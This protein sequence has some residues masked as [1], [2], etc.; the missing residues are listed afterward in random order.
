LF[1]AGINCILGKLVSLVQQCLAQASR[2]LREIQRHPPA[3]EDGLTVS[4]W[5]PF[6]WALDE[7]EIGFYMED[8]NHFGREPKGLPKKGGLFWMLRR[9]ARRRDL[10]IRESL[11]PMTRSDMVA[12]E[13]IQQR[14]KLKRLE[15]SRQARPGERRD[16]E[17]LMRESGTENSAVWV[18]GAV[19]VLVKQLLEHANRCVGYQDAILAEAGEDVAER[20]RKPT[21]GLTLELFSVVIRLALA[22]HEGTEIDFVKIAHN[23]ELFT[24][25]RLQRIKELDVV[26]KARMV[27][28]PPVSIG[29][30]NSEQ[31][32]CEAIAT[33]VARRVEGITKDQVTVIQTGVTQEIM[34]QVSSVIKEEMSRV[35]KRVE[36]GLE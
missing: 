1:W 32:E 36:K 12:M 2:R 9:R 14:E 26:C 5:Y 8:Y 3:P 30:N 10:D 27:P 24:T 31:I 35:L 4:L 25:V 17:Y 33:E 19:L 13:L 15:E 23:V 11:S 18:T 6:R 22:L 34:S 20:L 21:E 29:I 28:P 7:N 16:L